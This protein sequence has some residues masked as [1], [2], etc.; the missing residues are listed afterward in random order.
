MQTTHVILH[1]LVAALKKEHVKIILI[2]HF[3]GNSLVVQR[4]GLS[5]FTAMG[6]G[7]IP[8]RGTKI[9]Q[10]TRHSQKNNNNNNT[11]SLTRNVQKYFHVNM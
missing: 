7:S 1:F 8:G 4:L 11:F 9:P 6:L 2:I 10:A 5:A 3:L